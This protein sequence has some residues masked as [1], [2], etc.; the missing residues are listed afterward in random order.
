MTLREDNVASSGDTQSTFY[1]EWWRSCSL[2]WAQPKG[3]T[4]AR[5]PMSYIPSSFLAPLLACNSC[6]GLRSWPCLIPSLL[7]GCARAL[8][9]APFHLFAEDELCQGQVNHHLE[10]F[11]GD[12]RVFT[13]RHQRLYTDWEGLLTT[14]N[15]PAKMRSSLNGALGIKLTDSPLAHGVTSVLLSQPGTGLALIMLGWS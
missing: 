14:W 9:L 5:H 15:R 1:T 2:S 6:Q 7:C 8:A 4:L 12:R 10:I 13:S 3:N 11:F